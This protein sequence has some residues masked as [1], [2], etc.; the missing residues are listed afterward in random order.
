MT[1]DRPKLSAPARRSLE[2]RLTRL[3]QERVPRLE[4]EFSSTRDP[5]AESA[6]R[7]ARHEAAR[8]REAL[9]TATPLEAEP[10]D[11]TIGELGDTVTIRR[12]GATTKD[13]FTIAGELEARLDDTWVSERAPLGAALLN[14]SI[15]QV[16]T[17]PTPDGDQRYEVLGIERP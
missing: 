7:D 16:V 12:E 9:E 10:H 14:S 8:V 1:S 3:D 17:V 15:G 2:D 4:R 6:L 5:L 11:P 13:R